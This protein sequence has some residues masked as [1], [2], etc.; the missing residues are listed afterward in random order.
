MLF[1]VQNRWKIGIITLSICA[2][3]FIRIH[4]RK[5][6]KKIWINKN[7]EYNENNT[8]YIFSK[9]KYFCQ[10]LLYFK[11]NEILFIN[12]FK[13]DLLLFINLFITILIKITQNNVRKFA[14]NTSNRRNNNMTIKIRIDAA[15]DNK[16]WMIYKRTNFNGK[17]I[18]DICILANNVHNIFNS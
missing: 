11:K 3:K 1:K 15:I 14:W 16:I 5:F 12:F 9:Y 4:R 13:F 8:N 18:W 17:S 7:K 6:W 10:F 2:H